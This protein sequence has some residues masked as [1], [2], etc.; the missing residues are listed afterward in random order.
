MSSN[1]DLRES[2]MKI[3]IIGKLSN[4]FI[5]Q[6]QLSILLMVMII[7]IGV[8]GLIALPK[9]SLPEI[10][11]PAITIQTVY[12]GA[13]PEDVE[14]LVTEKIE[15]KVKDFEDIDTIQSDSTFGFSVISVS[16]KESVDI[17]NKKIEV[18]NAL[19]EIEFSEG[20]Q[21]P[22]SVIFKTSEIPLMNISV[23]GAYDAE[24]LTQIAETLKGEL[25]SIKGVDSVDLFGTTVK[26]IHIVTSESKMLTYNITLSDIKNAIKAS[27][28]SLPIG[29][30]E[31]NG[32]R[33]TIRIDE[34]FKVL[35]EIKNVVVIGRSG[36]QVF[37]KDLGQVTFGV[38]P[39]DVI[40]KTF[41]KGQTALSQNSIFMKVNRKV[42]SDV[43]GTSEAVESKIQALKGSAYPED[44]TIYI[45]DNMAKRVGEDLSNIQSS[46]L[47]GL[48]VV[49]IVL[50]L[51]IGI[52]ES[53]IVSITIPLSLLGTLGLLNLFGI[54]FNTFAILGL[55][56]ALGLLVDNSIIV[57][58]NIDRIKKL[59][60]NRKEAAFLGTNQVGFPIVSATLTTLAAFFPLV[61][62]PGI[63]GAF[64]STIPLTIMIT[65]TVSLFISLVITPS[66]ASRL[67]KD[68]KKHSTG[69]I[70][71]LKN[72]AAIFLVAGLSYYAFSFAGNRL[73]AL[74]MM[75]IF[76]GLMALK[77]ITIGDEGFEDTRLTRLYGRIVAWIVSKKRR[78]F[79]VI[80]VGLLLLVIS[81]SAFGTGL[82]KVS[83]FPKNEPDTLE[84]LVDT[85]GGTTLV[86]NEKVASE[87]EAM[88]VSNDAVKS[89]NVTVGGTE[90]D[91]I[92][93][94]V[95]IDNSIRNGYE[96]LE[97]LQ[98]QTSKIS[99]AKISINGIASGPPVGK[100]IVLKIQGENLEETYSFSKE[101]SNYLKNT[102]GVYNIEASVSVGVPQIKIGIDKLKATQLGTNVSTVALQLRGEL[103][104]VEATTMRV[105]ND[106]VDVIIKRESEEIDD[107]GSL[108]SLFIATQNGMM[109]PLH[110][111]SDIQIEQGISNISR[112]DGERVISVSADL[113]SGYNSND[114]T[115]KIKS[116]YD[117]NK[118]PKGIRI[119]YSGDSEGIQEN[120]GYLFQSMILA[121][122]LVFI[123]LTIQF[124]SIIQPFVILST[125]PMAIIGVIWGLV[126]TGNDFGFYAFM[127]LVALVGI[128]VNDAIVLIDYMNYLRQEGTPL[129]VAIKEAGLTRFNP[130]LATTLTTISGV[131]PLAFKE[132]YYAQFSFAL[133]FGLMMTTLMTLIFIPTIYHL[134]ESFKDRKGVEPYE[135]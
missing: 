37:I 34:S 87:I 115:R 127:G 47:S 14:L 94:S 3:N 112:E 78:S 103:S 121:V 81:V 109:I 57:M 22:K 1:K 110:S 120:F 99:G 11:F 111:I 125:I 73:L 92:K 93:F 102:E 106:E 119:I 129:K 95:A 68:Q 98:E 41:I 9:E 32:V 56:V 4:V 71:W 51:F 23:N 62:L 117:E 135:K 79:L 12:P 134:M 131:L 70:K 44:A 66:I 21:V 16:F 28:V 26:E 53:L 107:L 7:S 50:F 52:R 54:T 49:I 123:I 61:I 122:F 42:N 24:A 118:L 5:N 20:V 89:Y 130:V 27:N 30:S 18:D 46:A 40:N 124:R 104:G 39:V 91:Y 116:D 10:V 82:L 96:V 133:I 29:D 69:K 13:S 2:K 58:E 48:I 90:I 43:I 86:Q 19:R 67:L 15:N 128:A 36:Q 97:A 38:A 108:K 55:I 45:S 100:P 8:V 63:L 113:K 114:M 88:L 6:F 76:T 59:G 64:V 72:S 74:V 84:I 25:E 83:F 85:P 17:E 77:V 65:L 101:V 75:F 105:N 31:L 33:Y 126:I 60:F 35:D 80:L 132:A